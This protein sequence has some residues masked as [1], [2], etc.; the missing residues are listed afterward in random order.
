M[1]ALPEEAFFR[2]YVQSSFDD[3]WPPRWRVLGAPLGVSWVLTAALFAVGHVL[4]DPRPARLAVFF[5]ALLFGWLRAR[6]RDVL[7]GIFFH[8]AC[9][10]FSQTLA[11]GFLPRAP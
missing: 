6:T 1:I 4:T 3:V 9:N 7:P 5:P 10:L 2:G 11:I 8:A